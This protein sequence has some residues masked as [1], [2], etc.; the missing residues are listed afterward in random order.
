MN[1]GMFQWRWLEIAS[2]VLST[3]ICMNVYMYIYIYI[4]MY[5]HIMMVCG[6]RVYMRTSHMNGSLYGIYICTYVATY[7]VDAVLL[8]VLLRRIPLGPITFDLSAGCRR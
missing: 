5:T 2:H 7:L 3:Y 8:V 1:A 4:Y 6:K